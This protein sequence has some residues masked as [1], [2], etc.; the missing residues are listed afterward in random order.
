MSTPEDQTWHALRTAGGSPAGQ[1]V[2]HL[3]ECRKADALIVV[4]G[5]GDQVIADMI[6]AG[7]TRDDG[8]EVVGGK[9]IRV[10]HPPRGVTIRKAAPAVDHAKCPAEAHDRSLPDDG[11][12]P[13]AEKYDEHGFLSDKQ[14]IAGDGLL[15]CND[16]GR[17]MFYC[18]A[19][20]QYHHVDPGDECWSAGAWGA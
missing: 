5:N 1:L 19:D 9:R 2:D 6:A 13:Y 17:P 12:R 14:A 20:E 10:M 4:D 15:G 8:A 3:A 16:C 11:G 18:R 7:W